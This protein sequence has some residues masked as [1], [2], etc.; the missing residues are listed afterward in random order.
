M[1]IRLVT[2][3][4]AAVL[5]AGTLLSAPA[6]QAATKTRFDVEVGNTRTEGIIT[7]YGRSVR[8]SGAQTSVA[9]RTVGQFRNTG[10]YTLN[11]RG[12]TLSH[13]VSRAE[14]EAHADTRLFHFVVPANVKGGAAFVR[15][16]LL[17]GSLNP[18]KC[19]R[20]SR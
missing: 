14:D 19:K 13:A 8:L 10:G 15:I 12:R 9:D 3:L 5:S 18:L 11:S 17:D 7:W 20:Y 6:A 1:R 16:C 2:A 4:G